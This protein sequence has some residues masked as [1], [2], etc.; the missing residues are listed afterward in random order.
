MTES[1]ASHRPPGYD[2]RCG[3][4][5]SPEALKR[6]HDAAL[7][8]IAELEAEIGIDE[9]EYQLALKIFQEED[10]KYGKNPAP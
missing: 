8:W 1:A 9:E 6:H 5:T 10:R 3:Y 2:P 4:D 7:E